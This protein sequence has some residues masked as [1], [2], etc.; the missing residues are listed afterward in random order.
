MRILATAGVLIATSALALS[1]CG[2]G[3]DKGSSSTTT[4]TTS[5]KPLTRA[6]FVAQANAICAGPIAA[7]EKIEINGPADLRAHV[8]E[9][10]D[11]IKP[12]TD[13]LR[14]LQPPASVRSQYQRLL[15]LQGE[16][17]ALLE[18]VQAASSDDQVTQI[19]Q[20]GSKSADELEKLARDLG[21][22]KCVSGASNEPAALS[23]DEF[24]KQ[25]NAICK[26]TNDKLDA[27]PSPSTRAETVGVAERAVA[28]GTSGTR[29]LRALTAPAEV[30]TDFSSMV[31]YL[32]SQTKSSARIAQAARTND[33]AAA[34]AEVQAQQ[35]FSK[36]ADKLARQLGLT[37]CIQN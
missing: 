11:L 35:T 5:S 17:I 34:Q 33:V 14:A 6:Q 23:P 20:R 26:E 4:T 18:R 29:R 37:D 21:L 1:A 13:K 7:L 30:R 12:T 27:L 2:G 28:L 16:Q 8:G 19:A 9:A 24:K 10:L 25:A 31:G 36:A 3:D 22:T 15:D 32:E